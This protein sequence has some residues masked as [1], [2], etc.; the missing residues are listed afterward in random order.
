MRT[1]LIYS[2]V[3]Y[4]GL[5]VSL[6][7]LSTA[8]L[9]AQQCVL[10]SVSNNSGCAGASY[11][12]SVNTSSS[13][14]TD[15]RWYTS[16]TGPAIIAYTSKIN[17]ISHIVITTL[18]KVFTQSEKYWVAAVCGG[19]ESPRVPVE[20]TLTSGAITL[21]PSGNPTNVCEGS[22]FTLTAHG[23][24]NYSWYLG[25]P[26][27][28]GSKFLSSAAVY[29]PTQGGTYY[30]KGL[31][32]GCS[33]WK[34]TSIPVTFYTIPPPPTISSHTVAYNT[35][36]Y[37][38]ASGAINADGYHWFDADQKIIAYGATL[39]VTIKQNTKYYVAQLYHCES[40]KVP[41]TVLV[42]QLPISN[43]GPDKYL[44]LPVS[45]VVLN[46]SGSDA[47]GTVTQVWQKISGP[48]VSMSQLNYPTLTLTNISAGMYVFRLTVKDNFGQTA[49]DDVVVEVKNSTLDS[50]QYTWVRNEKMLIKGV[51]DPS[52]LPTSEKIV[53]TIFYNDMGKPI[54]TVGMQASPAGKDVI[55]PTTYDALGRDA[56][57]YLPVVSPI[58]TDGLFENV[59]DVNGEYTGNVSDFYSDK[60]YA[61]TT[62]EN[63]PLGR[64]VEQGST[65]ENWQPGSA[66]GTTK[67]SYG[68]NAV[69]E[70]RL[71]SINSAGLPVSTGTWTANFLP[72]VT[73]TNYISDQ[74][75]AVRQLFKTVDGVKVL[76]RS[77][78]DA[79]NWAETYYVYDNLNNLRFVIPPELYKN[80][81]SANNYTPSQDQIDRWCFQYKYDNLNR[82][83]ESKGP[84]T[85]WKFIV[86]DTHGNIRLTQDGNQR[87]K[88]EWSYNK[89]DEF[90]R[91]IVTGIFHPSTVYSRNVLQ[92]IVNSIFPSSLLSRTFPTT[93]N[94]DLSY[95]YYDNYTGNAF[96]NSSDFQFT[97]ESWQTASTAYEAFV[98]FNNVHGLVTGKS[99]KVLNSDRWL[100]T[101]IYYDK[102][103]KPIQQLSSLHTGGVSRL[104]SIHNF[105]GKI[106]ES[107]S[108]KAS[109]TIARRFVYDA[110]GRL[111][112]LY[113]KLN[114]QPEIILSA[115]DYSELGQVI[116]KKIHSADNGSTYLQSIDFDYNLHGLPTKIN[117]ASASEA[118]E[119]DYFG[120]EI[121]YET[122]AF[123]S[124]NI[125]RKDGNISATK[126]RNDL[127]A[128]QKL[129]NY[130]YDPL[131]RLSN[132]NFKSGLTDGAWTNE[133]DFYS[134][135]S[136]TYDDNGNIKT[137]QR[138]TSQN[139]GAAAID[140]L[141]YDYGTSSGNQLLEVSDNSTNDLKDNGF[142]DG[143]KDGDDYAYDQNGNLISDKNKGIIDIKYNVLN[144][145]DTVTFS[146]NSTLQYTYDASGRKLT[147]TY[148][149][150]AGEAVY[151]NDYVEELLFVNDELVMIH[152][153][154]GRLLLPSYINLVANRDANSLSEFPASGSVTRTLQYL[155]GQ[156]YVKG[157]C[158]QKT[159]SPGI[160]P[161][162]NE[163]YS[164]KSG[165][166]YSFKVLGYQAPGTTAKLYAWTNAGTI[167]IPVVTLPVGQANETWS[168]ITFT[169]PTGATQLKVGVVWSVPVT[170]NTVYINRVALYKT[171]WEYQYF[172]SDHVGS[173]RVVLGTNPATITYTATM[174]TENIATDTVLFHNV[175]INQ[176]WPYTAANATPGG[177]EVIRM[178]STYRVGP[179]KSIKVYPG[180]KIDA[181]VYAYYPSGSQYNP[182]PVSL[183]INAVAAVLTGNASAFVDGMTSAYNASN[184]GN[185]A[186]ALGSYQGSSKP[187][188][189]INYILFDEHY[190]PLE[191]KSTPVDAAANTLQLV[192]MSTVNVKQVGYIYVYL[193]YD[194]ESTA[195]L[196]FDDMKI[197]HQESP[198]LQVNDYYPYGL[199]AYSWIREGEQENVYLY[200]SK[201]V[202]APAGWQDFGARKY[203]ADL[204]RW[205][206]ADPANQFSS[207]YT[208]MGNNPVLIVDPNGEYGFVTFLVIGAAM[209]YSGIQ[210]AERGDTGLEFL[211]HAL[212]AG[213][214]TYLGTMSSTTAVSTVL[215]AVAP[216]VVPKV[217]LYEDDDFS[218]TMS[219]TFSA[220][221]VGASISASYQTGDWT[222]SV[223]ANVSGSY[224]GNSAGSYE[225]RIG[226]M[227]KYYDDEHNIGG[228]IGFIHYGGTDPQNNWVA[229]A[230]FGD[231]TFATSNDAGVGG[232]KYRTAAIE[233]GYRDLS[234]GALIYTTDHGSERSNWKSKMW[235]ENA[236]NQGSYTE[237][238]RKS[239]PVYVGYK[240]NGM[241]YRAGIDGPFVQD[242]VQNGWHYFINKVFGSNS[243]YFETDYDTP[244]KFY[245][246]QGTYSPYS[247][248]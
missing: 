90:D 9:H 57:S 119:T 85:S 101:V 25:D 206:A 43:A 149:N 231:F 239:S 148:F 198:V 120:M 220:N 157:V 20:F 232:D 51:V 47:E 174:E 73:S 169:I 242:F 236:N 92:D 70:V 63:S 49:A 171:D 7:L 134:E 214:T 77:K 10:P 230:R 31:L 195:W 145:P 217:T 78:V 40:S 91:I 141:M 13:S 74:L 190:R 83:I 170:N 68:A 33:V 138:Y 24:Y 87:I 15:H 22:G 211:T 55:V 127:S 173:P 60:P 89:Y 111:L 36:S 221:S 140:E 110:G 162:G 34:K 194:N 45:S 41:F 172:I 121:A 208:G 108:T 227:V 4:I 30:L 99:V 88:N 105:P 2:S 186:F 183:M 156:T 61:V 182:T 209:I 16:Q 100:H 35:M 3:V 53:R 143:N 37:I 19:I 234:A 159:G 113:H 180:D 246:Y 72:L 94:E 112:K 79:N 86:Y 128:N 8:T 103:N 139:S 160:Y 248:Y 118:G 181:S 107:R 98:P 213:A 14:V 56:K 46:G 226:G 193:S 115:N 81:K 189:F 184:N 104:S 137:L 11:S 21:Q 65:G 59:L 216:Y 82:I 48:S 129:Y 222:F 185:A 165:E 80:L 62:F 69:N 26:D 130:D 224:G 144:L 147:M 17:P 12:I 233:F 64:V 66:S 84:G 54:E 124:S 23:G 76:E 44:M 179:A 196:Y 39:P 235:G 199:T 164:V 192:T 158:K 151:K 202:E 114:E 6:L 152:H 132:A 142:K 116:D 205:L 241:S 146:N 228:S 219:P 67:I 237:G 136:L 29:S 163:V 150:P 126:W 223:S 133:N 96:F 18:T 125:V 75:Q 188:A 71:W 204:G 229:S 187:S 5:I 135:K 117:S 123:S 247:Q 167:S 243:A 155:N 38:R 238:G 200:Q 177:N 240:R 212:I 245:Y 215:N 210:S 50:T 27:A 102:Y 201:E 244:S 58:S 207:P 218:I 1:S 154:E 106:L 95:I 166:R 161:M 225:S 93:E 178:N 153:E 52:I 109:Q 122:D 131:G 28:P 97:P 32:T 42:N 203:Y 168:T 191:A 176:I 175:K 197:V